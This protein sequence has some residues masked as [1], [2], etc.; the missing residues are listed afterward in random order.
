MTIREYYK[1]HFDELSEKKK[2]H[3]AVRLKCCFSDDFFKNY[4]EENKPKI[5]IAK[6]LKNNDYRDVNY[7]ESRKP[8]FEKYDGIYALEVALVQ[9]LMLLCEY[10]DDLREELLKE[11]GGIEKL[12]KLV[13]DLIQDEEAFFALSTF[14]VNVISLTEELFPRGNDIY[15]IMLERALSSE[16]NE[17]SI[18]LYTHIMLCES[19]FYHAPIFNHKELYLRAMKN[20]D[21]IIA[22]NFGNISLDM[23]FEFLVCAK[24][25]GYIA[26]TKESIRIEAEGNKKGFIIDPRKPERLN[27]IDGAEHRNVLFVMSGLDTE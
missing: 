5:N 10:G 23:K 6:I 1:S 13:D 18:Y 26:A 25:I 8:F 4:L 14:A 3:F 27:T 20:C 19:K 11:F 16:Q 24:M 7:Y 21:K 12:Y 17:K 9:T 15:K 2:Y 22:E